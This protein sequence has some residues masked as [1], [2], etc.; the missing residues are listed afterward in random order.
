MHN[1]NETNYQSSVIFFLLI[2]V[3]GFRDLES[4]PLPTLQQ[5]IFS[6]H[7]DRDHKIAS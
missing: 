5:P 1:E 2:F 3:I 7:P 4:F 6:T